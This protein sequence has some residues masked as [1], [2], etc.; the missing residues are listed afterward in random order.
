MALGVRLTPVIVNVSVMQPIRITEA[1]LSII[2]V[3]QIPSTAAVSYVLLVHVFIRQKKKCNILIYGLSVCAVHP[4]FYYVFSYEIG[5]FLA[6]LTISVKNVKQVGFILGELWFIVIWVQYRSVTGSDHCLVIF[7]ILGH[8]IV[9]KTLNFWVEFL[10]GF[11]HQ[12]NLAR[13]IANC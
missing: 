12:V 9:L 7:P 3:D 11:S 4:C 6:L 13:L 5:V 10:F 2:D 8:I 1:V